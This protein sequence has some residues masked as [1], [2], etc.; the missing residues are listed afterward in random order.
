[1]NA[2]NFM[3]GNLR[4]PNDS[5]VAAFNSVYFP[6]GINNNFDPNNPNT[7]AV[8]I[9]S[10]AINQ[11]YAD[12]R[13][14]N[15]TGDVM[16]S[17]LFLHDHPLPLSG[18]NPP[19][20]FYLDSLEESYAKQA[21][22]KYYVD[23]KD[24]DIYNYVDTQD[25][26]IYNY[27]DTQDQAIYSFIETN[28]GT[29]SNVEFNSIVISTSFSNGSL[30]ISSNTITTTETNADLRLI[31]NGTG[32][33]DVT[34]TKIINLADP[35]DAQ[36]AANKA[37]VDGVAQ[38]LVIKPSAKVATV[39]PL[40]ATYNN[41]INGVDATLNLGPAAVLE[42]DGVNSWDLLDGVLVKDQGNVSQDG[43]SII[44]DA[45]EN[46]R[47]YISQIG[48]IGTDWILTRCQYCDE[49]A[50]VPAMY[51]FV[52][53]GDTYEGTGWVATITVSPEAFIIGT[54]DI[55]FTQFSGIGTYTAGTGLALNGTEF[56]LDNTVVKKDISIASGA[57][58]EL[59][60]TT[61]FG[62][63]VDVDE[64]VTVV[65]VLDTTV[66]SPTYNM[67]INSEAVATVAYTSTTIR[68]YNDFSTSLTFDIILKL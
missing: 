61:E 27:V 9:S 44:G 66:S 21:A 38:G 64:V 31:T 8:P 57:F 56:A 43:S 55:N 14:I 53:A 39:F 54:D 24:Q 59:T 58:Y 15:R 67:K 18:T 42:I 52:S 65:R 45:I 49:S 63:T 36:D 51:V 26:A 37:Y 25:Q 22:T 20:G 32:N 50:E 30:S 11:G 48:D 35:F 40:L 23:A 68:I 19:G 10:F 34:G 62:A 12:A 28:L 29:A 7:W 5:D 41:G 46:G 3:I 13:Y 1:M 47:Y 4:P 6:S 60:P 2:R 17:T 33:V 16:L